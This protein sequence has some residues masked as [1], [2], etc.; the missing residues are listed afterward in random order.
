MQEKY[1]IWKTERFAATAIRGGLFSRKYAIGGKAKR[2]SI[3]QDDTGCMSLALIQ[4]TIMQ[5]PPIPFSLLTFF[6]SI[7]YYYSVL[8]DIQHLLLPLALHVPLFTTLL[9]QNL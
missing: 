2:G 9:F 3:E 4:L 1:G 7:S 8:P 5:L 6:I